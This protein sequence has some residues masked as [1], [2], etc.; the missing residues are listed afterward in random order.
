MSMPSWVSATKLPPVS[1][2]HPAFPGTFGL[3]LP[4]FQARVWPNYKRISQTSDIPST[5]VTFAFTGHATMMASS[6][7]ASTPCRRTQL[8]LGPA[9]MTLSQPPGITRLAYMPLFGYVRVISTRCDPSETT[10]LLAPCT[11]RL[12]RL[13]PSHDALQCPIFHSSL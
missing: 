9:V 5:V 3:S 10:H 7:T 1:S 11:V 13:Q 6:R 4:S 2:H 12:C 8:T